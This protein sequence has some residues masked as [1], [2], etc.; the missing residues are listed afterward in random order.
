MGGY[1]DITPKSD[2]ERIYAIFAMIIGGGFYG[3]VVGSITSVISTSDANAQKYNEQM[4]L[5]QAWIE[6]HKELPK[7]LARRIRRHVKQSLLEKAALED[8]YVLFYLSPELR[9]EVS[10]YVISEEVR[11]NQLF[12]GMP[13]TVIAK[14][15]PIIQTILVECD[16]KIVTF[17]ELGVAMFIVLDGTAEIIWDSPE[18][19]KQVRRSIGIGDSFGEEV[20]LQLQKRYL[21]TVTATSKMSV[22][23]LPEDAFLECFSNVPDI[24]ALMRDNFLRGGQQHA[25]DEDISLKEVFRQRSSLV[26]RVMKTRATARLR[27]SEDA[28]TQS[29]GA[30][31]CHTIC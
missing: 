1:G 22:D 15:V 11:D 7:P 16:E 18:T 27:R 28:S 8:S 17:N 12:E 31:T 30:L 6:H 9:C 25:K 26:E 3:Y 20:V 4:D 5:I 2:T 29:G 10:R 21:Y 13:A 23:M 19:G 14:L 24:T